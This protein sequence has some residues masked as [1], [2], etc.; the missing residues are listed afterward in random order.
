MKMLLFCGRFGLFDLRR[1]WRPPPFASEA[2]LRR[3]KNLK[4]S[5][6]EVVASSSRTIGGRVLA[7]LV[8]A[9]K[10]LR[11]RFDQYVR[12]L[13]V[14]RECGGV[15]EFFESMCHHCGAANPVKIPVFQSILIVGVGILIVAAATQMAIFLIRVI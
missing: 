7:R 5:R 12:G 4:Y 14:C 8:D 6:L 13:K 15:V 1:R 2:S 10:A 11:E 3:H 9:C